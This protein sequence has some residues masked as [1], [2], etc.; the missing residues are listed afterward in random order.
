MPK[1]GKVYLLQTPL[2]LQDVASSA[3]LKAL[4][5][6]P[7]VKRAVD[8]PDQDVD[9]ATA[10]PAEPESAIKLYFVRLPRPPHDEAP[11][12][13]LQADFQGHVA[14]IK[15]INTRLAAKRVG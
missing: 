3:V 7:D 2:H 5:S 1:I 13:K 6:S 11:L 10:I 15:A 14:D 9:D 12:K 8:S 4:S